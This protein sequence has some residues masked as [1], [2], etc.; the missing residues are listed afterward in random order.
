M[1]KKNKDGLLL[2]PRKYKSKE[3]KNFY[4]NTYYQQN[5]PN[6]FKKKYSKEELYYDQL[7]FKLAEVFFKKKI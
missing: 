4:K 3:L 1:L 2:A 7:S 6:T 5:A